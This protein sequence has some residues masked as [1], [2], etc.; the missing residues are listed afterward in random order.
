LSV[1]G[2]EAFT[3]VGFDGA[4]HELWHYAL[5]AGAHRKPI[6]AIAYGPALPGRPDCWLLAGPDGTVHVVS[7]EGDAIDRF[8]L[9]RELTGLAAAKVDGAPTIL[10]STPDAVEAWQVAATATADE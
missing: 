7:P 9:G 6:E 4:G 2:R 10:V 8:A 1:S 3:A 5:P